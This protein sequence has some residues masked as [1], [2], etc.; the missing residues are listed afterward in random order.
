[1]SAIHLMTVFYDLG[2]IRS[3]TNPHIGVTLG[4]GL[5]PQS[6]NYT[7]APPRQSSS[8]SHLHLRPILYRF[9]HEALALL[10]AYIGIYIYCDI[11]SD[12]ETT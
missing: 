1:M 12:P 5:S 8:T 9:I 11:C 10:D 4:D 6:P 2:K 7:P 3:L